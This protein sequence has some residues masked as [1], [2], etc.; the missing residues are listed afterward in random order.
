MNTPREP[1]GGLIEA[2]H[3]ED[4]ERFYLAL[5]REQ[6]VVA[7]FGL[8][9]IQHARGRPARAEQHFWRALRADGRFFG[10]RDWLADC[11][12]SRGDAEGALQLAE[13]AAG[14]GS[15]SI[16]NHLCRARALAELGRLEPARRILEAGIGRW[17]DALEMHVTLARVLFD[18]GDQ[19]GPL[20]QL[21]DLIER[22]PE[23]EPAWELGAM[24]LAESGQLE[25]AEQMLRK[26]VEADPSA[27]SL[28][29]LLT[30]LLL[31]TDRRD[32]VM[33]RVELMDAL[34]G[35]NAALM[36]E[37]G[38]LVAEL[39]DIGGAL[40]RFNEALEVD[41]EN[42]E[43]LYRLGTFAEASGHAEAAADFYSRAVASDELHTDARERLDVVRGDLP[44]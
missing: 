19:R 6:P 7:Q 14:M 10:I 27:T 12:L 21:V 43:A 23:Y 9:R 13:K 31:R 37:V 28:Q 3:Y 38:A 36:L 16:R 25:R 8:G 18:L 33:G 22:E 4:A 35:G 40:D 20:L 24:L 11:R 39:G 26:A 32:E 2:G 42:A 30:E 29:F 1:D 5:V 17:P 34:A 44:S 41:P 15:R